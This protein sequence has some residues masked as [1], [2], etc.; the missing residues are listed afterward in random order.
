MKFLLVFLIATLP[1]SELRGA[2][3]IGFFYFKIPLILTFLIAI[4]GNI[5]MALVLLL[6]LERISFLLKKK[7]NFLTKFWN[8]ILRYFYFRYK[9]PVTI[10]GSLALVGFV[11]LPFP[12]T[13]AWSASLIAFIFNLPFKKAFPLIGIGIITAGI[14][15]S[16]I[17]LGIIKIL[18]FAC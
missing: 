8:F 10:L 18:N 4:L 14:L 2:I 6:I 9:K 13:G 5:F 15:V 16:L 3:P 7:E 11:A 17:C 12:L 1:I